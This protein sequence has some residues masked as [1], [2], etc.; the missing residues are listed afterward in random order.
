[1]LKPVKVKALLG[2][3]LWVEYDDGV[4]G[5]VDLSDMAGKGVF[6]AWDEK[7][8]FEKVHIS[9]YGSIAWS[10]ELEI[11]PDAL[12]LEITGKSVEEVFPSLKSFVQ[13]RNA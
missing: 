5:E 9:P 11:C 3:R 6:K 7:G 1:M 2:Y 13:S 12:Y 4:R 10:D 8:F